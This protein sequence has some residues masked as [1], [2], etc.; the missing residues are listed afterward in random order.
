M[1]DKNGLKMTENKILKPLAGVYDWEI[2]KKYTIF[3]EIE[4]IKF[5][6][7]AIKILINE[8]KTDLGN[9]FSIDNYLCI[10]TVSD[11]Q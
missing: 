9:F 6:S 11:I 3:G 4:I 10:K 7:W 8:I 1:L 2:N 5:H